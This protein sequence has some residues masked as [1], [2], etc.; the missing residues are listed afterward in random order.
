MSVASDVGNQVCTEVGFYKGNMVAIRK[1]DCGNIVLNRDK[2][3]ELK[4][5]RDIDTLWLFLAL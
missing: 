5:V 2:L 1:I 4:V 3:M